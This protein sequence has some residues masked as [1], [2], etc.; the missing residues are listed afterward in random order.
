MN[1]FRTTAKIVGAIYIAGMVV[2]IGG[3]MLILSILSAPEY[4]STVT[5][6][7]MMIAFGAVLWL[8]TVAG[9]AAH[10]VLMFP[11]LK[12]HSERVAV[13]YL[14]FRIVDAVFIAIMVLFILI[15]IPLGSEYLK[16]EGADSFF[17]ESLGTLLIK[18]NL[19]A[20][21][22]AMLML[23]IS[24][25]MLCY[26]LYTAKLIPRFL[27]VWGF[28]GYAVILFGSVLEI[29]GFDLQSIHTIPGGLWELFAGGW[30]IVKGFN[31]TASESAG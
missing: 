24:G 10:G 29:L 9:D 14:G 2:G 26:T 27:S 25:V 4:L 28:A 18:A 15:Q 8:M 23:G 21:H 31:A 19:C 11:V 5:A 3:N 6:N 13:G 16:A 20:Y 30:L 7:S 17:L 22:I 1:K 12:P